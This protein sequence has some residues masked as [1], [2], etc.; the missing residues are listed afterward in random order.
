MRKLRA[1]QK[2]I[3]RVSVILQGRNR[4][5]LGPRRTSVHLGLTL[6]DKDSRGTKYG[7]EAGRAAR[8]RSCQA[9][10][11]FVRGDIPRRLPLGAF[12]GFGLFLETPQTL[13]VSYKL[14]FLGRSRRRSSGC[15][16]SDHRG[17]DCC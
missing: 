8:T 11:M 4:R 14:T 16:I 17:V 5:G 1:V 15:Y 10:G 6:R 13:F 3:V 7:V 2:T 12:F 9:G